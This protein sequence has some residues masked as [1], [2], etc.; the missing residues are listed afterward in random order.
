MTVSKGHFPNLIEN[1]RSPRYQ[2]YFGYLEYLPIK[3]HVLFK[4]NPIFI[5]SGSSLK[6]NLC[7]RLSATVTKTDVINQQRTKIIEIS[8]LYLL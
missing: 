6:Q 3:F 1:P 7:F 4:L 5:P 2:Y 8:S